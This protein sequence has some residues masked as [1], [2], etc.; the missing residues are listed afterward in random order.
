LESNQR[1]PGSE[2]GATTSSDYPASF[3]FYDTCDLGRFAASCGGRNRSLRTPG[4]KPGIATNSDCPAIP[5]GMGGTRTRALV[6]KA[7]RSTAFEAAAI[8]HWLALPLPA[9]EAG[10]E[11]AG[12]AFNRRAHATNSSPSAIESAQLDL[13]QRSPASGAGGI[14]RLSHTPMQKRPAGVEPAHPPW[15]GSRLPLHHGRIFCGGLSCQRS[16]AGGSARNSIS[17]CGYAPSAW[18][19]GTGGVRTLTSL[20]KS[21]VCCR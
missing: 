2:P 19:S 6:L 14:A 11:P 20:V 4:S 13:N 10:F 12:Y 7:H 15:Q 17:R 1:P 9:A 3:L 16:R 5:R 21:E 8:A 18:F